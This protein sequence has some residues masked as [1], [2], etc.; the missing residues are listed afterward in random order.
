MRHRCMEEKQL[1]NSSI[2]QGILVCPSCNGSLSIGNSDITCN[3]CGKAYSIENG[4][5]KMVTNED[6]NDFE[7]EQELLFDKIYD[8]YDKYLY[9]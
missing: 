7:R 3:R 5:Y 1:E 6:L 4:I 8:G 9:S 2:L